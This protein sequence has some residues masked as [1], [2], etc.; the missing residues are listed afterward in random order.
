VLK[1]THKLYFKVI[2]KMKKY[3]FRL[4]GWDPGG[5]IIPEPKSISTSA[6]NSTKKKVKALS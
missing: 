1:N 5:D 2:K 4:C 3:Q 6:I